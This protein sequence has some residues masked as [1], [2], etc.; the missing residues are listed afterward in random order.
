MTTPIAWSTT[1]AD[2]HD[3]HEDFC[4]LGGKQTQSAWPAKPSTNTPVQGKGGKPVGSAGWEIK[5]AP[6][7]PG[8]ATQ[9]PPCLA[10]LLL[11]EGSPSFFG[12]TGGKLS[13]LE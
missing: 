8:A 11:D 12:L 2:D 3:C 6:Q 4:P 5:E 7:K 13:Y 1:K 10:S 9:I